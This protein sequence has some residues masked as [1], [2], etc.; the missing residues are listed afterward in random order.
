MPETIRGE[1]FGQGIDRQQ[2]TDLIRFDRSIGTV[3]DLNQGILKRQ[4][5]GTVLD[6]STDGDLRS[7]GIQTLLAFE[8]SGGAEALAGQKAGDL[9][10]ARRV[11]KLK[12]KNRE[13]G[14]LGTDKPVATSNRGHQGRGFPH[15]QGLDPAHPGVVHVVAWVIAEQVADQQQIQRRQSSSELGTDTVQGQNG[16]V[17]GERPWRRR[18]C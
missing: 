18:C 12:L 1:P 8:V 16:T 6:Q 17:K 9:Q 11:L 15:H 14:I 2:P 10:A 7:N 3:Q 4:S 13:V 5:I